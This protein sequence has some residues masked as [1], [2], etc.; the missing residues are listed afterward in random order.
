MAAVRKKLTWVTNNNGCL[1]VTSHALDRG[2]YVWIRRNGKSHHMHRHLYERLKGSIPEGMVV[3]HTCD[4]PS[5]INLKHLI[6]GTVADNNRDR[7][8]RG[9]TAKGT[10]NG[11]ARLT[12]DEVKEI[13]ISDQSIRTLAKEYRVGVNT[14]QQAKSRQTWKHLTV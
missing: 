13:I 2:G 4:N 8:S 14:I 1:L 6:L 12:E 10:R 7:D 11:A 9:R 5:C 3:R